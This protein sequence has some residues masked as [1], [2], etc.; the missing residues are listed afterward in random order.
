[1]KDFAKEK[2][3]LKIIGTGN[4]DLDAKTEGIEGPEIIKNVNGNGHFSIQNG[5]VLGIDI[6][7]LINSVSQI[8]KKQILPKGSGQTN[9]SS[10]TGSFLIKEGIFSN[11]DLLLKTDSFETKGQGRLN[12]MNQGIDYRLQ[13]LLNKAEDKNNLLNLYGL[14]IPIMISGTLQNLILI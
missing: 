6:P 5:A 14:P 11:S 13:T 7:N 3:K 4:V 8:T 9:F 10:L 12:L 2:S 1:M